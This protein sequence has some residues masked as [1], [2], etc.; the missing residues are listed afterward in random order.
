MREV[1]ILLL[2]LFRDDRLGIQIEDAMLQILVAMHGRNFHLSLFKHHNLIQ[3]RSFVV[4][5]DSLLSLL[6]ELWFLCQVE[7]GAL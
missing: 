1:S 4:I 2:E 5:L 3:H 6:W 7:H